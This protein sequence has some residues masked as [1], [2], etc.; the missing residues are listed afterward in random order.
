MAIKIYRILEK[1]S[2]QTGKKI[3]SYNMAQ[4]IKIFLLIYCI[5]DWQYRENILYFNIKKGGNISDYSKSEILQY[6]IKE[7]VISL[8]NKDWARVE[9]I[10]D[11]KQRCILDKEKLKYIEQEI[12]KELDLY[13]K[14]FEYFK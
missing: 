8:K 9:S 11:Y 12:K 14:P 13:K 5:G 6:I 1:L 3:I 10:N 4:K 7:S 2:G